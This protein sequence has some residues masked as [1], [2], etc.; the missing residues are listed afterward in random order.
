MLGHRNR[1]V[2]HVLSAL[3]DCCSRWISVHAISK[4]VILFSL[5]YFEGLHHLRQSTDT[6]DD[7][8]HLTHLFLKRY[9]HVT[10]SLLSVINFGRFMSNNITFAQPDEQPPCPPSPMIGSAFTYKSSHLILLHLRSA[11]KHVC[12]GHTHNE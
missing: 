11:T 8:M 9:Y 3:G 1:R 2:V 12:S 5:I 4:T 6:Y 7:D 10:V